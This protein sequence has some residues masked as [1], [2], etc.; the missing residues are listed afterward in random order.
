MDKKLK[1]LI[2]A[3]GWLGFVGA[4]VALYFLIVAPILRHQEKEQIVSNTS[5]NKHFQ[6]ELTCAVDSFA[7]YAVLRSPEFR[8]ECERKGIKVNLYSSDNYNER[9][10]KFQ[11][12]EIQVGVFTIDSLVKNSALINDTPATL[13]GLIDE[14]SADAVLASKQAFPNID[15][16]N[17]PTVRFVCV[18]DS[19][20]ETLVRAIISYYNLPRL[21]AE[22]FEFCN[23]IDEVYKKYQNTP[24]T[25]KKVFV[26]WEPYVSKIA[27]HPDYHVLVS[28][29]KFPGLIVDGIAAN[30]AYLI[31]NEPVV[32]DFLRAFLTASYAY[33]NSMAKLLQDD[34]KQQS[35]VITDK[36]ADR[37]VQTILFKNTQENYAHFGLV[38][39]KVPHIEALIDNITDILVKTKG[40]TADPTNGQPNLLYYDA[41]LKA[42]LQ[43]N[44][45]PGVETIREQAQLTNLTEEDWNRLK[46]VGTLNVKRLVFQR[47]S[48]DLSSVDQAT[49]TELADKLKNLPQYYLQ[50]KATSLADEDREIAD[51]N[52]KLAQ[53]RADA[54]VGWLVALGI[55][56]HRIKSSAS[57]GNTTTVEFVV[58]ELPY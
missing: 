12:G 30:R 54:V 18:K 55:E 43:S 53:E 45:H 44:Y 22:P 9:I 7:A 40:I 28:A 5:S 36:E 24:A 58:G 11:S 1:R 26:L 38:S 37:L 8:E 14:S 39:A 50:V 20:S 34:A 33:R 29:S 32:C 25:A 4:A 46:P 16:L 15:A 48:A 21:A 31:K 42:L 17:D 57:L 56:S 13:I 41:P 19:P 3:A 2:V 52:L 27:Q 51:A 35:F 6:H 23:S 10:Q 47:G 49:L